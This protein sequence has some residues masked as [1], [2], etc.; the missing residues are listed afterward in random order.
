MGSTSVPSSSAHCLRCSERES[1]ILRTEYIRK[2]RAETS[3]GARVEIMFTTIAA[4]ASSSVRNGE[5]RC[6]VGM[7]VFA[8]G[9]SALAM[10]LRH[11]DLMRMLQMLTRGNAAPG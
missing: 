1:S 9:S 6:V 8:R 2:P 3:S 5:Q 7:R 4:R 11:A 10:W